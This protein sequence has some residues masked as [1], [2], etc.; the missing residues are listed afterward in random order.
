MNEFYLWTIFFCNRQVVCHLARCN[1]LCWTCVGKIFQST[2]NHIFTTKLS[3]SSFCRSRK[4]ERALVAIVIQSNLSVLNKWNFLLTVYLK[5]ICLRFWRKQLR[6]VR[7]RRA[8][9]AEA[10]SCW[11]PTFVLFREP[12]FALSLFPITLTILFSFTTPEKF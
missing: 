8:E 2:L 5:K 9:R 11:K 1:I 10:S 6:Q 7:Y 12:F 3:F 4:A